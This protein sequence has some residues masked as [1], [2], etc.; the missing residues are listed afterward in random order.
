L[1]MSEIALPRINSFAPV[2]QQAE[3][4]P[5]EPIF[6]LSSSQLQE[7][8]TRAVLPLQAE[9]QDLKD[10]V[11]LQGEKMAALEATQDTQAE[12]ELNMLRL[13]NDLRKDKEPQ[14]LQRD[15]GEILRALLV[16]NG[17]KMLATD[18]RKK[19][20][21]SRS[22]FSRL[23]A[24]MKDGIEIKPYHLNKSWQVLALR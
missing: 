1:R 18:A 19:M 22:R 10:I 8:I 7:I 15:R 2:A 14:P 17:G 16:A 13:I 4:S 24:T 20:H 6:V 3:V 5:E 12:N 9:L 11:A 23:L 21:L